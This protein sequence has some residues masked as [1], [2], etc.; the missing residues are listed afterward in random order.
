MKEDIKPYEEYVKQG[1]ETLLINSESPE[2][3]RRGL[4]ASQKLGKMEAKAQLFAF[5]F[6]PLTCVFWGLFGDA[7]YKMHIKQKIRS[8]NGGTSVAELFGGR[9]L[10]FVVGWT[11]VNPLTS[12]LTKLLI[13]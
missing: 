10:L 13:G 7:V 4:T 11:L 6:I 5:S 8:K 12:L 1:R 9:I 2:Y 3:L